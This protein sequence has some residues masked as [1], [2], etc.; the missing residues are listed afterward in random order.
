MDDDLLGKILVP[1]GLQV[2]PTM[3][4]CTIEGSLEAE[5]LRNL[6]IT[7]DNITVDEDDPRDLKKI[8]EKHHHVARQVAAG[9][10]QRLVANICGY[11]EEYISILLNSPAMVEL[12]ELYRIQNG[13]A[14]QL[15]H[16]K[17]KTVGLKALELLDG[18]LDKDELNNQELIS[19]AKL[20]LDRSGHGPTST[21]K[22][23]G[24]QHVFDHAKLHELNQE[25]RRRNVDYIVPQD[26]VRESLKQLPAPKQDDAA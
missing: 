6:L 18:K 10:T 20:G 23:I 8:R 22:H 24:E 3:T 11:S 1:E 25:A 5:D 7:T 14:A 21:Q 4:T 12:V 2:R 13:Q 9:L 19:T 16:E 15:A 26:E 17:L